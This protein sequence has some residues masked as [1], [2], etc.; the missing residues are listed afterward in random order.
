MVQD[1]LVESLR[2]SFLAAAVTIAS[3]CAHNTILLMTL[4][5]DQ[6]QKAVWVDRETQELVGFLYERRSE[7][8]GAGNFKP[9]TYN[10][11]ADHIAPH[12]S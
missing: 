11:A 6:S 10:A 3:I 12:H 8:D 5:E 4:P 9:G 2:Q 7:G 1:S